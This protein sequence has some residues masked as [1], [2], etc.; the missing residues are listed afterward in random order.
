MRFS[1]EGLKCSEN[2]FHI[3]KSS[4]AFEHSQGPGKSLTFFNNGEFRNYKNRE[5]SMGC[6]LLYLYFLMPASKF[7][8]HKQSHFTVYI[9]LYIHPF[10]LLFLY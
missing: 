10:L 4:L 9:V 2:L 7:I 3:P 6:V 1:L 5:I 8:N